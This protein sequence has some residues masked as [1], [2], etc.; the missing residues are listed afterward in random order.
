MKKALL[1]AAYGIVLCVIGTIAAA[2]GHGTY[3]FII[4]SS[5]PV[6]LLTFAGSIGVRAA[7]LG[8]PVLWLG[9]GLLLN[10]KSNQKMTSFFAL[11]LVHYGSAIFLLV[12]NR[13]EWWVPSQLLGAFGFVWYLLGQIVIWITFFKNIHST[14]FAN[15]GQQ[16]TIQ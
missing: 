12:A 7:L 1:G 6:W 10:G 13:G 9:V 2:G 3:I 14:T 5:A 11:M 4:L 8:I 15:T 16:A